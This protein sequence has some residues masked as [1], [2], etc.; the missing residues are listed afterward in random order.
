MGKNKERIDVYPQ[1]Q[2]AV[3]GVMSDQKMVANGA[4]LLARAG[5]LS[6]GRSPTLLMSPARKAR[7][8]LLEDKIA[9]QGL[10]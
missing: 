5:L 10:R 1:T 8:A 9:R 6:F 2:V 4:L 3:D 7:V